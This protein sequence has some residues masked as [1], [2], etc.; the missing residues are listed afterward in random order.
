MNF[1]WAA[2]ANAGMALF[3]KTGE[4]GCCKSF[5]SSDVE[6]EDWSAAGSKIVDV[7]AD[8]CNSDLL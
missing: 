4:A 8:V 1:F 5:S 6:V 2:I 7:D 3:C